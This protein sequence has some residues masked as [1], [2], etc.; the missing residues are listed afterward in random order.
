MAAWLG[1]MKEELW[2]GTA[3]VEKLRSGTA[4]V[5]KQRLGTAEVKELWSGTAEGVGMVWHTRRV[6]RAPPP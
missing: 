6:V 1:R 3:G 2:S 4:E 5:K